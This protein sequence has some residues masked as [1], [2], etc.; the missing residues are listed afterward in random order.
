MTPALLQ[1][2]GH[3]ERALHD[4]EPKGEARWVREKEKTSRAFV[5]HTAAGGGVTS[6]LQKMKV[7]VL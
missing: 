7:M 3:T 5:K 4:K 1:Q 2:G 6:I